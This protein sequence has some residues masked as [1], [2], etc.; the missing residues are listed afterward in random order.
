MEEQ[1][2]TIVVSAEEHAMLLD[3]LDKKIWSLA[4][5]GLPGAWAARPAYMKLRQEIADVQRADVRHGTRDAH[6]EWGC[7]CDACRRVVT[8]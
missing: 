5:V 3:A 7:R 1:P 8:I 2:I 4:Q 6:E